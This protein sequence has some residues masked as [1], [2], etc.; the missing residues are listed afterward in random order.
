MTQTQNPTTNA[1]TVPRD[2]TGRILF[3]VGRIALALVLAGG[4]IPKLLADPVMVTMFDDIG[5]GD[6]LRIVVGCLEI[7]G[8]IGL[9][10]RP[11]RFLAALGLVGLLAGAA[12]TNVVAL[13]T[14]PI[15]PLAL[16][17]VAATVAVVS[18]RSR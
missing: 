18:W 8:A 1:P 6:P 12:V 14:S 9:F 3:L 17:A 4:A 10:L 11:L 5:G 2:R 16:L 7:A 13:H 15:L